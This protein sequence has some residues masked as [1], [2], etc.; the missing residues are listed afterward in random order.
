MGIISILVEGGGKVMGDFIDYELVD[1]VYGF[2]APLIVGGADS[3]SIA[4]KGAQTI[5]EAINIKQLSIRRFGDNFLVEGIV[6]TI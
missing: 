2:Y 6:C 3:S 1:R 5:A 4:G